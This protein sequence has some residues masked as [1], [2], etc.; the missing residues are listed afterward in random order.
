M[1]TFIFSCSGGSDLGA[2]SDLTARKLTRDGCGRMYCTAGIGGRV[3]GIMA[4][5]KAA[6]SIL[7]IDGCANNCARKTLQQA[8]FETNMHVQLTDLGLVKG[9]TAVNDETV[10]RVAAA[11]QKVLAECRQTA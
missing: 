5:T 8:G 3:S 2:V 10:E 1:P 4:S 7:I 6:S 11:A 9:Q